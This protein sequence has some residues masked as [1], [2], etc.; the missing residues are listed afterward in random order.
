MVDGPSRFPMRLSRSLTALLCLAAASAQAQPDATVR[1]R[2]LSPSAPSQ[3]EVAAVG[4]PGVLWID[5]ARA[6]ELDPGT[7]ITLSR[8]GSEVWARWNGQDRRARTVAVEAGEVGLTAGRVE[9]RYPGRL[10][11]RVDGRALQLVNHAPVEPYVASVVASEL[12]FPEVEAAKAQAVLARTYALRRRGQHADYDLDDDQRAQ[13]YRGLATTTATSHRAAQETAGQVLT[14]RGE[15]ADAYYFSSS[16]GHTADNESLWR[17]APVPYLRGVPD[18]YDDA[19]PDHQWRTTASRDAV[20]RALSDRYGGRVE[21]IEV[22]RRS[23]KG[24]VLAVRLVGGRTET[25]TGTQLRQAVN[26][27][28]G[29]RTVRSTRYDVATEGDRLVFTGG[30]FGHGVGMSQ[31]GALGQARA[32]RSYRD[33]LAFYFAGTDVSGGSPMLAAQSGPQV[34]EPVPRTPQVGSAGDRASALRTRYRPPSGR[35]WPTPRHQ[36]DA[37]SAAPPRAD[38]PRESASGPPAPRPARRTAW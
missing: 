28:V 12:G 4:G 33:I 10:A 26:A 9:R 3:V 6:A 34:G 13:V 29:A 21:R 38:A 16:G 32:G 31:Y 8:S 37:E 25:I 14:Y 5:G 35:R 18:P 17:G 15:I 11:V 30:G 22:A 2:L 19:S 24:R 27:A 20:L 36:A 23:P 1:V 7:R